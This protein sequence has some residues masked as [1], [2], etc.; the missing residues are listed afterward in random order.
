[1][2]G[3]VSRLFRRKW[4]AS[5]SEALSGRYRTF[6]IFSARSRRLS[7]RERLLA[8]KDGLSG[9]TFLRSAVN[10]SGT[11]VK[12][13]GGAGANASLWPIDRRRLLVSKPSPSTELRQVF[14]RLASPE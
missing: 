8:P 14:D 3:L 10:A 5:F 4:P 11:A 6:G 1:V 2:A 13:P 12:E 7:R 9:R